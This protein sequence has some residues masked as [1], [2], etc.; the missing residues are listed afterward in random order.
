MDKLRK[1]NYWLRKEDGQLIKPEDDGYIG[2]L[3]PGT[4]VDV[5]VHVLRDDVTGFFVD[6]SKNIAPK[7]DEAEERNKDGTFYS[8]TVS[9]KVSEDK[10]PHTEHA[11][12]N[13]RLAKI[14][15]EGGVAIWEIALISQNGRFFLTQQQVY[16][17]CCYKEKGKFR[18]PKF[19]G[20]N[21]WPNIVS[22]LEEIFNMEDLHSIDCYQPRTNRVSLNGEPGKVQWFNLSQGYGVIIT[23]EGPARVHWTEI[24]NGKRLRHLETGQEVSFKRLIN[25][26]QTKG[27]KTSFN[28][29]AVGV[30]TI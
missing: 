2:Y 1:V 23:Q 6:G 5:E 29:E 19:D 4:K 7:R 17:F 25:P 15:K 11:E 27:N 12:N 18:C 16:K 30:K 14:H 3:K 26:R 8:F 22:F 9:I 21:G 13:I 28:Q 24:E 20:K 10:I